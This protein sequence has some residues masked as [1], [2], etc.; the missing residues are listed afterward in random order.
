MKGYKWNDEG[1]MVPIEVYV[2]WGCPASGKTTYVKQHMKNGDMV[3][4]L[5]LIKQALTMKGKTEASDKI[6]S[7]AIN[8]RNYLYDLIENRDLECN[9]V[10]VVGGLP[11]S[12]QRNKLI[13]KLKA[14]E[15]FIEATKEECIERAKKDA[16]RLDKNKQITIINKWFDM[17]Y[18]Y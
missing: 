10:W 6:V 8:I 5:D 14:K 4:D 16:E 1:I 18:E 7:T 2:V 9:D 11:R 13:K 3:V 17:Y 12:E 15:I